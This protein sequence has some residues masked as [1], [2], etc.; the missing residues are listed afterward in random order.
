MKFLPKDE[1]ENKT[2]ITIKFEYKYTRHQEPAGYHL[3]TLKIVL[4]I[5]REPR[6]LIAQHL[7]LG[8]IGFY[9]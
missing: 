4:G 1:V 8:T 6:V 7:K 3:C 2:I 5:K 9:T